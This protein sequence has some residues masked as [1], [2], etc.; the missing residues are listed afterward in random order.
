MQRMKTNYDLGNNLLG[1][2]LRRQRDYYNQHVE[3]GHTPTYYLQHS[4]TNNIAKRI[5]GLQ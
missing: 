5:F 4:T 2:R 1:Y 3:Y